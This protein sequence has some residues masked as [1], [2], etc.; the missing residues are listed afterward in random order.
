MFAEPRLET[1]VQD[2]KIEIGVPASGAVE[3]PELN[4]FGSTPHS[5]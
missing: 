2:G 1:R 4:T 3:L 5:S